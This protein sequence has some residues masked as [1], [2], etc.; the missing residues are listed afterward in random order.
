M[1]K[2]LWL[3]CFPSNLIHKQLYNLH[4]INLQNLIL[5]NFIFSCFDY[6]V[7][8]G[9]RDLR[10][11]SDHGFIHSH[12]SEILSVSTPPLLVYYLFPS[13]FLTTQLLL[14]YKLTNITLSTSTKT[15]A[16][17][18]SASSTQIPTSWPWF[19]RKQPPN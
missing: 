17:H 12:L 5:V 6:F 19:Y 16:L 7:I 10:S 15:K 14:L 9:C 1:A 8:D 3:T 2:W 13:S 4:C 18:R 11:Y